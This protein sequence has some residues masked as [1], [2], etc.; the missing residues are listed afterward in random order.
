MVAAGSLAADGWLH[1]GDRGQLEGD[2]LLRV[3]GRID[4]VIVTGGE[5]V[6]AGEVEEALLAHPAVRD[7]AVMGT[8]D[9]DWG[10][11]VTAFVVAAAP[12]DAAELRGHCRERIAAFKVPKEVLI[13]DSLPRNAAGKVERR[14]L[15]ERI[16]A[17][18]E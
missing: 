17:S 9:P 7:A 13:V 15:A 2:G 5:N 10:A 16:G 6:A 8:P 11:A 12:V 14:V 3:D 1:T 4:D 18:P